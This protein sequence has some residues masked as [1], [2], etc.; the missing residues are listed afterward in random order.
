MILEMADIR[1]RPSEQVAF[2]AAIRRGVEV[3]KSH[4]P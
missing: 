2:H 4:V 1:I 3:A